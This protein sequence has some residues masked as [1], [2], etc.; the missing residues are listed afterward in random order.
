M[1]CSVSVA[2]ERRGGVKQ[3]VTQ[4]SVLTEYVGVAG[5]EGERDRQKDLNLHVTKAVYKCITLILDWA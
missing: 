1:T 2:E 5:I 4:S 3:Y